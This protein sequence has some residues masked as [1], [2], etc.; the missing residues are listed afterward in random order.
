MDRNDQGF[1]VWFTGLPSA[2]KSTLAFEMAERL[3][4]TRRVEVLDADYIR[5]FIC[6]DLGFSKKDRD[7]NVHRI[8]FVARLLARNGV[9]VFVAAISPYAETRLQLR[10][11]AE[12]EIIPFIEIHTHASLET[13]VQRDVKGLYAKAK[14]GEISNFTGISAPYEEPVSP[15]LKVETDSE[16]IEESVKKIVECLKDNSLIRRF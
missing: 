2:G 6:P 9:G 7:E 13:V 5:K 16:P 8:G 15:D 12:D 14:A 11:M 4:G 3:R 10:R 1:I